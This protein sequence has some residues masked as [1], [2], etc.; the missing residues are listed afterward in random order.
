MVELYCSHCLVLI[1]QGAVNT[2][3]EF[4]NTFAFRYHMHG[5]AIGTLNFYVKTKPALETPTWTRSGDNGDQWQQAA[6]ALPATG[7]YSVCTFSTK[8][9]VQKLIFN[10]SFLTVENSTDSKI[11]LHKILHKIKYQHKQ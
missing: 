2:V 3:P 4:Y 7:T 9:T 6:V 11:I 10:N 1:L 5:G 8:L